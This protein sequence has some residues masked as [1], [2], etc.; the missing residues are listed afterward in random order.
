MTGAIRNL[1][2]SAEQISRMRGDA[3]READLFSNRS[4]ESFLVAKRFPQEVEDGRRP[5]KS[6]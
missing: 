4:V 6:A 3:L 2:G 5:G 1:L